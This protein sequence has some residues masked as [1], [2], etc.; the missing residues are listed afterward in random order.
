MKWPMALLGLALA[1]PFGF[2]AT[3][4]FGQ[5]VPWYQA[6]RDSSGQAPDPATTREAV[7]QVYAATNG[8]L[9]SRG[10][11]KTVVCI[12]HPREFLA[13]HYLIP[14]ILDAG[15]AAWTQGSRSVGND[16]RL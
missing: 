10:Q 16:L 7:I 1:V 15:C 3:A 8:F 11:P 13:T 9:F 6:R 2:S 12:M 4:L 5:T 14:D